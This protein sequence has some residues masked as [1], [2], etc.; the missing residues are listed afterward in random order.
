LAENNFVN[1]LI[2]FIGARMPYISYGWVCELKKQILL[3]GNLDLIE[4]G[5]L[6][7]LKED[8]AENERML[9]ALI[10]SLE[11][12]PL[13]PRPLSRQVGIGPSS[14]TKWE[15]N[16]N[17]SIPPMGAL[18]VN[19]WIIRVLPALSSLFLLKNE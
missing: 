1:A 18:S 19:L 15:K 12:K 17:N 14:S 2:P 9:K 13:N 7:K 10:K 5:V 3:A 16:Q 4:K 6:G 8:I 11:N